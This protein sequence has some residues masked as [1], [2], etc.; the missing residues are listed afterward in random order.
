MWLDR[1]QVRKFD[2]EGGKLS[3]PYVVMM[4]IKWKGAMR[5]LDSD[6]IK[7]VMKSFVCPWVDQATRR[8]NKI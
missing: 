7:S 8:E 1:M 4:R 3:V 6:P 2:L 5:M